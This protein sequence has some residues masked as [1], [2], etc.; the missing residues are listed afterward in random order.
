MEALRITLEP[1]A[2]HDDLRFFAHRRQHAL[3]RLNGRGELAPLQTTDGGLGR[4]GPDRQLALGQS[5]C[6]P[7]LSDESSGIH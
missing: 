3:D 1:T 5:I 7:S 4:T 6:D 2:S